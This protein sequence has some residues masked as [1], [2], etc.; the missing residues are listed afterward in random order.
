MQ[1]KEQKRK[2]AKEKE[3]VDQKIAAFESMKRQSLSF[4][5]QLDE[6][7]QKLASANNAVEQVREMFNSG[8]VKQN[9]AGK[10]SLVTD[11]TEQAKLKTMAIQQNLTN[12]AQA[13]EA[14]A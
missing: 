7:T 13:Q 3:L 9:E 2:E 8:L 6:K 11:P 4:K 1:I 5:A 14:E 12:A 10:I